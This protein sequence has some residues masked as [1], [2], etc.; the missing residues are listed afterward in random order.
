ML[1]FTLTIAS[2]SDPPLSSRQSLKAPPASAVST[3]QKL[4]QRGV[5][6]GVIVRGNP[7]HRRAGRVMHLHGVGVQH[8]VLGGL[9]LARVVPRL[10]ITPIATARWGGGRVLRGPVCRGRS[11]DRRWLRRWSCCRLQR[12]LGCRGGCGFWGGGH[13]RLRS[14]F[15]CRLRRWGQCVRRL[16]GGQG[17]AVSGGGGGDCGAAAQE[18]QAQDK[19]PRFQAVHVQPLI[20]P[21]LGL[22][23][24]GCS[25][26]LRCAGAALPPEAPPAHL[27]RPDPSGVGG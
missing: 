22:R 24:R 18:Q 20:A 16:R 5:G 14:G 8:P 11:G 6:G 19:Q 12:R 4:I 15:R 10:K 25:G 1:A 3:A 13:S 26:R 23:Y 9:L 27:S 21:L 17:A 7:R 2:F